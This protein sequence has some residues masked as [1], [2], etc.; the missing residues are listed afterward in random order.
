[1]IAVK[2]KPDYATIISF[3][4]VLAAAVVVV[5]S[6][7]YSAADTAFQF[8]PPRNGYGKILN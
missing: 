5:S 2:K 8:P 7:G 3:I 1:M 4:P 6:L